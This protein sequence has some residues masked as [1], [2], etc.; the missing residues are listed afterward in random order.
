M[1]A[2]G[3]NSTAGQ[4]GNQAQPSSMRRP[5][6]VVH[7]LST[8]NWAGNE[9]MRLEFVYELMWL[10]TAHVERVDPHAYTRAQGV[11]DG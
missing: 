4:F 2:N 9:E 8:L 5:D 7:Y 1:S 3:I 11:P 6:R 10:V